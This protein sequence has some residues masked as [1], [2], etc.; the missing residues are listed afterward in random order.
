MKATDVQSRL[1]ALVTKCDT[2]SA[3]YTILNT[4]AKA[5]KIDEVSDHTYYGLPES[6]IDDITTCMYIL[7]GVQKKLE[8]ITG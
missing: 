3:I 7:D 6:C 4:S 2:N 5:A 1:A 8:R